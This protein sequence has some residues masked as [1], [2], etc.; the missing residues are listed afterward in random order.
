MEV[1]KLQFHLVVAASA[2]NKTNITLICRVRFTDSSSW[3]GFPAELQLLSAHGD[4]V[5]VPVLK[6]AVAS[7]KTRGSFR[8]VNITLPSEIYA[9]YVDPDENFIFGDHVLGEV[10]VVT[11]LPSSE[12]SSPAIDTMVSCLEKLSSPKEESL[13]EILRHILLEKFNPKNRNVES[14][15]NRFEKELIRFK[16]EG[17][18]QIEVLKSC[19]D[20]SLNNWFIVTQENLPS[21][22]EWLSWREELVS[23]FGDSSFRPVCSAIGYKYIGG[24]YVDY[25]INKEKLLIEVN[26]GFTR[27]VILDLIVYGLPS[28]IVK[29]LNKNNITSLQILK[30]KL[31]KYE[32]EE[33]FFNDKVKSNKDKSSSP[34]SF[35]RFNNDSTNKSSNNVNSGRKSFSN[36]SNNFNNVKPCS[37]CAKKG[38]PNRFHLESNCWFKDK[39][40]SQQKTINNVEI[41]TSS[42]EEDIQKN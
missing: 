37:F 39:Q 33:K 24:S 15:C 26:R 2:D 9:L 31:K 30:E 22:A 3:F 20:P 38:F 25:A 29:S 13:K 1:Q 12:S 28:R 18:R 8:N 4:L 36:N 17:R 27:S 10:D 32:G 41:D 11:R 42:S 6:S 19:L 34:S 14:W 21:H 23:N 5:K 7:L 35:R 16:L 40:E